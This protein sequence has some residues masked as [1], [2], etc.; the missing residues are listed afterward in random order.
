MD[1]DREHGRRFLIAANVNETP[2]SFRWFIK[3]VDEDT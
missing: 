1:L 2:R 3:D